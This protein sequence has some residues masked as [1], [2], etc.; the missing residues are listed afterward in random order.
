VALG[1]ITVLSMCS[2]QKTYKS[3][4]EPEEEEEEPER[5][6]PERVRRPWN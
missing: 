2:F 4:R 1:P 6:E 5:E 3:G